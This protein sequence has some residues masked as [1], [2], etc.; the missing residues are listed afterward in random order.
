MLTNE[1]GYIFAVMNQ[2][3]R[4]AGFFYRYETAVE[5]VRMSCT[6]IDPNPTFDFRMGS[7]DFPRYV[8]VWIGDTYICSIEKWPMNNIA[9]GLTEIS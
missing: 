2:H 3:G 9:V 8:G 4:I 7:R 1:P 5:S 6:H